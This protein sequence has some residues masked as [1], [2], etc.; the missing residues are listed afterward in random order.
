MSQFLKREKRSGDTNFSK[1]NDFR[2]FISLQNKRC[3][4]IM[5]RFK[6]QIIG[7]YGSAR[8]GPTLVSNFGIRD[9]LDFIFDDHHLKVGKYTSLNGIMVKP[10]KDLLKIKPAVCVILAYLHLKKIIC[11]NKEY[12]SRGGKFLSLYPKANL[13]TIKNYKKFI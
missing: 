6:T 7:A 3:K 11:K 10:T 2:K 13:I 5:I 12:L 8:S 9:L 4:K 1:L